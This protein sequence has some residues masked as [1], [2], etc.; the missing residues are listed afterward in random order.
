[1]IE[2]FRHLDLL[3]WHNRLAVMYLLTVVPLYQNYKAFDSTLWEKFLVAHLIVILIL[4][5]W[6]VAS[7]QD[8]A[9]RFRSPL[10]LPILLYLALAAISWLFAINPLKSGMEVIRILL[11]AS[12]YFGVSRTYRPDHRDAWL[13]ASSVALAAVSL[14]GIIQ[15][16]G[17]GFLDWRS[18]GLPSAT[19]FYRNYAAMYVAIVLPLAFCAFN[20]SRDTALQSLHAIAGTLGAIFL[21]YTRTRG[22]WLGLGLAIIG[23]AVALYMTRGETSG[24]SAWSDA[25]RRRWRVLAVCGVVV[26][27]ATM[28]PPTSKGELE[29]LP[30]TKSS[31]VSAVVSILA[32]QGAGRT[33]TWLQSLQM[34]ADRPVRGVGIG[35]WDAVYLKYA[36]PLLNQRGGLFGRPH[37]DYLWV[38]TEMGL[39]GLVLYLW[40]FG[41]GLWLVWDRLVKGNK[42]EDTLLLTALAAGLLAVSIH[43][44]FSFPR[45]RMTATVIPYLLLGWIATFVSA[46]DSRVSLSRRIWQPAVCLALT[47]LTLGTTIRVARAYRAYFWAD[48]YQ[49]YDRLDSSLLAIDAAIDYGVIDFRMFETKA[50]VHHRKDDAQAALQASQDLIQYH[51]YNPWSHH[52]VG[53]FQLELKNYDLARDAFQEALKYGPALGRIRRDLGQA[54]EALGHADS[55]RAAYETALKR[56]SDDALLRTKL[57]ALLVG[58]G[59]MEEAQKH[60]GV[61][62]NRLKF[63]RM[64]ADVAVVGDVAMM[65]E[66][67]DEAILAYERAAT[68]VPDNAIYQSKLANALV[69][70]G[71]RERAVVV[72]RDLLRRVN[73]EVDRETI[74]SHIEQLEAE[75]KDG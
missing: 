43:A 42:Q 63:T 4:G 68:L 33:D 26:I 5:G 35:N 66:A 51:P 15:Y 64:D 18:A 41:G 48:A 62:A 27:C 47:L 57:A 53:L 39:P 60:I 59:E 13:G 55:A 6:L 12:I 65:A 17:L 36:G 24:W 20:L 11:A 44:F 2:R 73:S 45:E 74:I 72:L 22:A 34:I 32:G 58:S 71:Q 49:T 3:S 8:R 50:L 46:S 21:I 29:S 7:W 52:K 19:F 61:A 1:V 23:V 9:R 54:Y 16:L 14:I 30:H 70:S 10:D 28:L 67:Y 31:A 69:G 56:I 38:I 75:D 40:I 25:I 37:N